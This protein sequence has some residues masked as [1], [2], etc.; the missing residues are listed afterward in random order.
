[1]AK[2]IGTVLAGTIIILIVLGALTAIISPPLIRKAARKSFPLVEGEIQLAG[3]DGPVRI[4]RDGYGIPHIYASTHHDLFFSQGYV[5][6]QDRFWQMDF[7]RH[8]GSGRLAELVGKP[9]LETDLFLRTLGW[10]RVAQQELDLLGPDEYAI[11]EAYSAGVNAYISETTATDLS[12]E[13]LFLEVLNSDYE[14]PPWTP[15]NSLT[16]AKAM[17]WDLRGNLDSEI[18]RAKLLK[19]LPRNQLE[20]IYPPYP[21]DHPNIVPG[22]SSGEE[23][24]GQGYNPANPDHSYLS[25]SVWQGVIRSMENIKKIGADLDQITGGGFEGIGSNSWVVHGDLTDTGKPYLVNDPHLGSQMPSIWYEVGLHCQENIEEC[26]LNVTGF[27][28]AGVPGVVIGHNDHI[29][30]GLTNIGPDVMDLYIEKTNPDHPTQYLTPD[31]WMEMESVVEIIQIAGDD[32]VE[33]QVYLTSHG[34]I[35]GSEYGLDDFDQT[36]GLAIPENY[37]L[38]LRWTALEPSCVFCAMWK[39]NLAKDWEEFR[40][41]AAQFVV[42]AQNLIYADIDGNI[43]YQMPGNIPIRVEGHDGMLPVPGWNGDYDW[44]GYIPFE[45]LPHTFN[46]ASGYIVTANNAVVGPDYPYLITEEWNRGFRAQRI[47]DLLETAP[48]PINISTLK[49]MQGDNFD[50]IAAVLVPELLKLNFSDPELASA[51]EIL[52]GWNYQADMDSAPAAL[53]MT[54]WQNLV[55]NTLQD[56]LPEDFTIGVGSTSKEI[57]RQLVNQPENPW[58]NDASTSE[59]ELMADILKLT[60]EESYRELKKDFGNDPASWQWGE[61]HTITFQNQVMSSFPFVNKFFNRGPFPASGGNEIVNAT[62]WDPGNPYVIDWLPSMRMIVNLNDL[63]NSLSIHTT[64][65]SGHAYHP[66]YIDMADLWRN[67]Y[68]HPML[69]DI[70]HVKRQTES[71]LILSP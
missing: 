56:N 19:T 14:P 48:R 36:T 46:P 13:Y 38:A 12:L 49:A 53:F 39:I 67:I 45:E 60:F 4:Y 50:L 58:W 34:P 42:P 61:L 2:K 29:A 63:S 44:Q 28:F 66:H 18:D 47:V 69:W 62:G 70:D 41:A 5:H 22:E 43:G 71:L 8:L 32:P 35:I 20:F 15:L 37:A 11:L 9:M 65:Q 31:G 27:S 10:E 7:W 55:D 16:W 24:E 52:A 21:A 57:I 6:A 23:V 17:A 3:L 26:Q 25:D 33:H 59:R 40:Q 64:G 68:Y 54:F 51:Q 1:M 30:W